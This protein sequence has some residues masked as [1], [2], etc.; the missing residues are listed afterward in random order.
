MP[1]NLQ[2]ERQCM[3]L[4]YVHVYCKFETD[5]LLYVVWMKLRD[6]ILYVFPTNVKNTLYGIHMFSALHLVEDDTAYDLL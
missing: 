2:Q 3:I 6:E 1:D 4:E 5:I